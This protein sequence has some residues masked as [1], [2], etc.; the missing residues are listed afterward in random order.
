MDRQCRAAL[1]KRGLVCARG[2]DA[3]AIF[4][5]HPELRTPAELVAALMRAVA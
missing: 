2:R 5:S 4:R 3:A 1:H